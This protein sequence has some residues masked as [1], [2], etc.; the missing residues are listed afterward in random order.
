MT[1]K[2]VYTE[3]GTRYYV[4]DE[5]VSREAYDAAFPSK[6]AE[7]FAAQ[8]PPMSNTDREFLEGAHHNEEFNH[9]QGK[10]IGEQYRLAARQA[11]VNVHGKRYLSS[12]AKYPGDPEAWVSGRGDVRRVVEKRGWSSTG[13]VNVK[14]REHKEKL[15]K[16]YEVADDIVDAH[17][18]ARR[19]DPEVAAKPLAEVREDTKRKLE[20][21]K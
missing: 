17:T 21:G 16:K 10:W 13:S 14:G 8:R 11:G 2:I 3:S 9:G 20:G 7:M 12:L 6:L 5:E 18:R 1:G 4:G 19:L 15:S